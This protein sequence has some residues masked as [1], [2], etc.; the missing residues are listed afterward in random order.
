MKLI[1]RQI[2]R[3]TQGQIQETTLLQ[4]TPSSLVR[5]LQALR[6]PITYLLVGSIL[7]LAKHLPLQQPLLRPL[8]DVLIP[9]QLL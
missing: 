1:H 4:S 8:L 6:A 2:H 3:Q 9:V 5:S 7:P